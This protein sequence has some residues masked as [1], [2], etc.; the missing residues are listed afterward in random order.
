MKNKKR[1]IFGL[2]VI[3]FLLLIGLIKFAP[4]NNT[5]SFFTLI[6]S[7]DDFPNLSAEDISVRLHVNLLENSQEPFYIV[8]TA[9]GSNIA[10][11]FK[12]VELRV[13]KEQTKGGILILY[14]KDDLN[15]SEKDVLNLYPNAIAELKENIT[16]EPFNNY[17]Y[18][19]IKPWGKISYQISRNNKK[20]VAVFVDSIDK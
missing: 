11:F 4:F 12:S 1:I 19:V 16:F 5:K 3:G 17:D 15:I 14:L 10:G 7:L 8:K 9:T 20:V 13:P 2:I 6:N 18:K